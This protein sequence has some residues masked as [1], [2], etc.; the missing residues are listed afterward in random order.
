MM[1]LK[2][3]DALVL[4]SG[5]QDSTT[6]L[7]WAI[8]NFNSVTALCFDYGQRH[9]VELD[10]AFRIADMAGV[11]IDVLKINIFEQLG[12]NA[13]TGSEALD[14]SQDSPLPNTFVPG[15]NLIMLSAAAAFSYNN[16]IKHIVTG[17]CET[18]YS[19][20]PDCRDDTIKSL[21]ATLNLG[22]E[23]NFCLHTPLMFLSKAET[24]KLARELGALDALAYSHT[25]YAGE[26]PPCQKC[27]ACELRAK[28]FEKAGVKDPLLVR[29]GLLLG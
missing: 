29:A 23:A 7:F 21:Q 3:H 13:L 12:G 5:G 6:C 25:C 4:F 14:D 19:G 24:V 15:R 22:M 9:K 17:V 16:D 18:D 11:K 2:E 8:K 26:F 1:S 10:S 20:Y 28:G 27:A